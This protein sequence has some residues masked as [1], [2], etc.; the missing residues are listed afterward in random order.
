MIRQICQRNNMKLYSYVIAQDSGLAPNPFWRLLTL[1]V[2]KPKIRLSAE[3]GDW[4]IGTGSKKVKKKDG[5]T[6]DFAGKLVYAMKVS[7]KKTM[8]EYDFYCKRNLQKK[9]PYLS[10]VDWRIIVGDSIYDYSDSEI[11]RLR[12]LIHKEKNKQTDL[13][14]K[15]TL[16]SNCF[17]YFGDKAVDFVHQFPELVKDPK[18][19]RGHKIIRNELLIKRFDDWISQN[20]VT[21]KLYGKP[22]LSWRVDKAVSGECYIECD[23]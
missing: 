20:F 11:P 7:D 15:Y 23:N 14:G 9:I 1:N 19:A 2:C 18:S 10:K 12:K 5:G 4:I 13:S 17:F 3:R 6:I 16:L 21:N 8:K 22:Q